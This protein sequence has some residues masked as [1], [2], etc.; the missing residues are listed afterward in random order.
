MAKS[1][2]KRVDILH[3]CCQLLTCSVTQFQRVVGFEVDPHVVVFQNLNMKT[4]IDQ[5]WFPPHWY[6]KLKAVHPH[7]SYYLLYHKHLLGI[8]SISISSKN[9][10][11]CISCEFGVCFWNQL[12]QVR[13]NDNVVIKNCK[14]KSCFVFISI[15]LKLRF[16]EMHMLN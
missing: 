1:P 9:L 3:A 2:N 5:I 14:I 7:H 10:T 8:L 15:L 13:S 11:I 6:A 16:Q 4:W 12:L